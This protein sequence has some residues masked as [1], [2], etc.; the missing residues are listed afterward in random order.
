MDT[1]PA[2][3]VVVVEDGAVLLAHW[4]ENGKTG[5][6]LPGGGMEDHESTEETAVREFREETGFD[7]ALDGLLGVDTN[8]VPAAARFSKGAGDLRG[9]RVIYRGHITG[10]ELTHEVEGTTDEC[11]WIPLDEVAS[12]KRV[13]LVDA[14]MEL[15][16][17]S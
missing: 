3:Y 14:A 9:L 5:W 8:Y 11:R 7:V 6:T 12:L 17:T 2:S 13:S 10:G 4:N 16:R 1:R 15:L